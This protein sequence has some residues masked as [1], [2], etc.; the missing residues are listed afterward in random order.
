MIS[1][2]LPINSELHGDEFILHGRA[3]YQHA[4]EH[5]TR[6]LNTRSRDGRRHA[7]PGQ[8]CPCASAVRST[9]RVMHA[10]VSSSRR[11]IVEGEIDQVS[12]AQRKRVSRKIAALRGGIWLLCTGLTSSACSQKSESRHSLH[13]QI[14]RPRGWKK[15]RRRSRTDNDRAEME[16][17]P[18]S[19]ECSFWKVVS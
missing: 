16:A 6:R 3:Q 18:P 1:A 2:W 8:V 14:S 9:D 15:C 4:L 19:F 13:L 7:V 5:R 11:G 17:A 12:A 10:S